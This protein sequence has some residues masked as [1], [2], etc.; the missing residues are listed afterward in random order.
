[1]MVDRSPGAIDA[2]YT[3]SLALHM[4]LKFAKAFGTSPFI[5]EGDAV[6]VVNRID[7]KKLD[8]SSSGTV[9]EG[10]RKM[11]SEVIMMKV[12]YVKRQCNSP[13]HLRDQLS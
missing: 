10:I 5:L 13:A 8:L 7:R 1:M 2:K 12:S 3:E 4:G 9:I 11:L 6:N